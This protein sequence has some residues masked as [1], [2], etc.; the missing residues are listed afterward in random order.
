MPADPSLLRVVH[1]PDPVL[2]RAAVDVAVSDEL[3]AVARRMIELMHEHEGIGLAAPQ[4]GLPWRLFVTFVPP[5]A[6]RPADASPLLADQAARVYVNPVL[7]D[8]EGPLEPF[9]EGCLSLPEIHGAVLRPRSVTISALDEHG[10]PITRRASGLLARCWQHEM[11]HLNGVLII[12]RMPPIHRLK[13][14][15]ALKDLEAEFEGPARR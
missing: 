12:D 15:S 11:D 8:P 5:T 14:R 2:R 13:N 4:V 9:D 6:D 7:S 1:Y 3:R 10:T